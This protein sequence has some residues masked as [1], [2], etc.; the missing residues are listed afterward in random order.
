MLE[1]D[2]RHRLLKAM[3]KLCKHGHLLTTALTLSRTLLFAKSHMLYT[4]LASEMSSFAP[5][6]FSSCPF[7]QWEENSE[8]SSCPAYPRI[9]LGAQVSLYRPGWSAVVG[10]QLTATFVSQVIHPP[11]PPNAGITG[12]NHC[13]LQ[14]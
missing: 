9:L 7:L 2:L 13:D 12:V 8:I 10:S 4:R 11:L 14:K 6:A 3:L 1:E 5:A